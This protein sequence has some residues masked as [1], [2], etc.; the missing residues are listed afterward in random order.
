MFLIIGM[1]FVNK[2]LYYYHYCYN[3]NTSYDLEGGY[4]GGMEEACNGMEGDMEVCDME[5]GLCF[6]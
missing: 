1:S 4:C 6:R 5:A 2:I 3:N